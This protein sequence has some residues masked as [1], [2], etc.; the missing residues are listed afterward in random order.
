MSANANQ[1]PIAAKVIDDKGK[2]TPVWANYFDSI[3]QGD[4]GTSF[5]P[6][7][8]GLTSIG[9]PTISGVYYQ[10]QGFTDFY[11]KIVP[12]TSTSSTLGT[13]FCTL[14]FQVTADTG[15]SV[16]TGTSAVPCAIN[17]AAGIVYFPNWTAITTPITI[18]GR[19]NS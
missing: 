2:V 14:P 12:G 1:S 15:G 4:V 18:S 19:V 7:I 17:S 3:V 10:N 8:T 5:K 13:T 16:V 9:A 11:I 6:N